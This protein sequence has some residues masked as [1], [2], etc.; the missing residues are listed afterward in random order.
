MKI[1]EKVV[2]WSEITGT[3]SLKISQTNF[4]FTK[5]RAKNFIKK[6]IF[7]R[8]LTLD[9][10]KSCFTVQLKIR[11]TSNWQIK[12]KLYRNSYSDRNSRSQIFLNLKLQSCRLYKNTGTNTNKRW[13]FR[14]HNCVVFKLLSGKVFFINRKDDRNC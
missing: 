12:T 14:I 6:R 10:K 9:F 3:F 13:N 4:I 1:P 2:N 11:N 8:K 5:M 7:P